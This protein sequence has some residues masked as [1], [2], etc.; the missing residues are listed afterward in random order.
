MDK[1][2]DFQV[3]LALDGQSLS[4]AERRQLLAGTEGLAPLRGKWV[5]FT[6]SSCSRP[7]IT[8]LY[9]VADMHLD[10]AL[11]HVELIG[12]RSVLRLA[13]SD[14]L[15]NCHLL[16]RKA[17]ECRSLLASAVAEFCCA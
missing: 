17:F 4:E 16:P 9:H 1:L 6:A 13:W 5:C 2:L 3:D 11:A 7:S 8:G 15:D 12:D 14:H 10:R